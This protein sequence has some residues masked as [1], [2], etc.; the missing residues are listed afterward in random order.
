MN[1]KL[2]N[3][4]EKL[5]STGSLNIT[6]YEY[7]ISNRNEEIAELLKNDGILPLEKK[8]GMVRFLMK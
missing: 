8:E 5:I 2:L 1:N 4:V 6:E 3:I 7:L